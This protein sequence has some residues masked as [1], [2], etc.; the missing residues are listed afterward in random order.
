MDVW[1]AEFEEALGRIPL[2][3]P[4]LDLTLAEYAKVL[5]SI[6]DIPT[7]ENPIESLHLLFTLYTEF[8]NN[9]H[10][11]AQREQDG[12]SDALSG[13]NRDM[14]YGGADVMEINQGEYK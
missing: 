8:R 3:S 4:D 13:R 11:Q 9:P 2:P 12:G 6:V 7:Y 10:F 1:P 5:C 14:E